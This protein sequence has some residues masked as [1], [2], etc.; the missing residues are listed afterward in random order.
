MIYIYL[1]D[2]SSCLAPYSI[3]KLLSKKD[4]VIVTNISGGNA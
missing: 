2:K 3:V 1:K 4:D